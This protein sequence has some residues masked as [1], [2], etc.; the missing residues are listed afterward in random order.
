MAI[1]WID[2]D[3]QHPRQDG[4]YAV[5]VIAPDGA[6]RKWCQAFW[7]DRLKL[8]TPVNEND[9]FNGWVTHW[10]NVELPQ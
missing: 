1:E 7:I 8:F 9:P 2:A 10:A 6:W 5:T 3:S 4:V